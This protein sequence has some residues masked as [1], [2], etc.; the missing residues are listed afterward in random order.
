MAFASLEKCYTVYICS[1][2]YCSVY[3]TYD[4]RKKKFNV[5]NAFAFIYSS[6]V[7]GQ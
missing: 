4:F 7:W 2:F 6:N 5:E 1:G 3:F